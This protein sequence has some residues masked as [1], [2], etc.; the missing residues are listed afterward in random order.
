MADGRRPGPWSLDL[1]KAY[2]VDTV[3]GI[4]GIHTIPLYDGLAE[5]GLRHVTPRHEQGAGFMADGYARVSGKPG[6]CF[7][8]TGPGLTNILTAL[9]QAYSDSVPVLVLSSVSAR[10]HLAFGDGY[11]HELPDQR[12]MAAGVTAFSHTLQ[13]LEDLPRVLARAFAVFSAARPRPVHVEI[14]LDLWDQRVPAVPVPARVVTV[15]PPQPCAAAIAEAADA[16]GR[17]ERPV[18]IAGGGAR[19]AGAAVRALAERLDAPVV[20]TVNGRGLLPPEHALAV[21]VSPELGPVQGLLADSDAV[22]AVGTELGPTDFD[23]LGTGLP[24][25]PAPR[26]RLDIDPAQMTGSYGADIA[27]IGDAATGLGALLDRVAGRTAAPTGAERADRTRVAARA[28]LDRR[29]AAIAGFLESLRDTLPHAVIVGDSTAP[30]YVGNLIFAAARPGSWFNSAMGF[31]T[32]GYALPAAHGAALAAGDRPVICL[33]GD[34]GLH[35][36][37][38]ELAALRDRDARVIVVVWNNASYGEIKHAMRR[39]GVTPIGVELFTPDWLKLAEAYGIPAARLDQTGSL[40]ALLRTAA[41]RP[42]PSLIQV[43][44]ARIV[45]PDA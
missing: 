16:L 30:V 32:L 45:G 7:V 8:I 17:A 23:P 31:G 28:A 11:L 2:G 38:G 10:R 26:I 43:D 14:P 39:R 6:V 27:L 24:T 21:P 34:G 18:L 35:F 29:T 25:L 9:G 15:P 3:F 33:A 37:L 42:G 19:R 4:P 12:A 20:M 1:L 41:A 13:A 5:S 40:P 44:E 36:T 22:L